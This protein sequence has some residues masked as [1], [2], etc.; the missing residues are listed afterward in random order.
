MFTKDI[1]IVASKLNRKLN[2]TALEIFFNEYKILDKQF[3]YLLSNFSNQHQIIKEII[4]NTL[5]QVLYNITLASSKYD[6]A[7]LKAILSGNDEYKAVYKEIINEFERD[8]A[9]K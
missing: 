8:V 5:F 9:G 6:S 4:I 2:V 1:S 7:S 3:A